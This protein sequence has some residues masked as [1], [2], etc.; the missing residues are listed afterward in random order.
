MRDEKSVCGSIRRLEDA[1]VDHGWQRA[2]RSSE[3]G[4]PPWHILCC[5]RR[6]NGMQAWGWKGER[7][8]TGV[9]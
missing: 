4:S 8:V 1:A 5:E 9:H 2:A 7:V 6:W 3:H